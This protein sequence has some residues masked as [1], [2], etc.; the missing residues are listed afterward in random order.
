MLVLSHSAV[1]SS[2]VCFA[3]ASDFL[4]S[5]AL[6]WRRALL[7]KPPVEEAARVSPQAVLETDIVAS[8]SDP[9]A[10]RVELKLTGSQMQQDRDDA[11]ETADGRVQSARLLEHVSL[12]TEQLQ[13]L[14]QLLAAAHVPRQQNGAA[15]TASDQQP[16]LFFLPVEWSALCAELC[17]VLHSCSLHFQLAECE[18]HAHSAP[19]HASLPHST[20][21][22]PARFRS[23][24]IPRVDSIRRK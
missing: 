10:V 7:V 16:L 5:A 8:L 23:I 24:F 6:E 19:V 17:T 4:S 3:A 15:A 12:S 22:I 11:M 18:R 14:R 20:R 9:E 13:Q 2:D 21:I 1:L